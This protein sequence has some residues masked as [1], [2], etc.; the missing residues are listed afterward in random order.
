MEQVKY[1]YIPI[2]CDKYESEIKYSRLKEILLMSLISQ[3]FT[4]EMLIDK[5][6]ISDTSYQNKMTNPLDFNSL[7]YAEHIFLQK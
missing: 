5:F 4:H 1:K 7:L 6:K 2:Y 3:K